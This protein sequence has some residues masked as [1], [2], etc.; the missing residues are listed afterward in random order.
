MATWKYKCYGGGP[1]NA[2]EVWFSARSVRDRAKHDAVFDF[3]EQ[4]LASQW[5]P[6]HA[7]KLR[8]EKPDLWE[9]IITT[10]VAWRIFGWFS[11]DNEFTIAG[12][13]NHKDEIYSPRDIIKTS[14][15]RRLEI[16][17]GKLGTVDCARPKTTFDF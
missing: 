10:D 8:G 13:G 14:R 11:A 3:L 17:T 12:I 15:R 2:W 9:V 6:P 5:T 16:E 4:R 1:P 7:K